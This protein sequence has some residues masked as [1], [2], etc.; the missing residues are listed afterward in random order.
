MPEESELSV[1][2]W[3]LHLWAAFFRHGLSCR[4]PPHS[5]VYEYIQVAGHTYG[6]CT[7]NCARLRLTLGS[8]LSMNLCHDGL[9]VVVPLSLLIVSGVLT[10]CL[11][12]WCLLNSIFCFLPTIFATFG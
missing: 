12:A 8:P 7:L 6:R 1:L 9:W 5:A 2:H 3:L 11:L 10:G 4:C